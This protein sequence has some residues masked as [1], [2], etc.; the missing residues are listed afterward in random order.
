MKVLKIFFSFWD[1]KDN[2]F[3]VADSMVLTVLLGKG[4]WWRKS[5]NPGRKII[6][7]KC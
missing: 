2:V 4:F 5:G 7:K 1:K 6:R 3:D